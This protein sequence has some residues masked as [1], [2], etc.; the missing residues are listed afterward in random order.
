MHFKIGGRIAEAL[1]QLLCGPAPRNHIWA[2][3]REG[4]WLKLKEWSL[5]ESHS[6]WDEKPH[7]IVQSD[8]SW[9]EKAFSI[10]RCLKATMFDYSIPGNDILTLGTLDTLEALE[11]AVFKMLGRRIFGIDFRVSLV[12]P[13]GVDMGRLRGAGMTE[14]DTVYCTIAKRWFWSYLRYTQALS[15]IL[16]WDFDEVL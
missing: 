8:N 10:P 4:M 12:D 16:R 1:W 5:L 3:W 6:V 15:E 9:V 11:T 2:L 7:Y 13:R 14:Q